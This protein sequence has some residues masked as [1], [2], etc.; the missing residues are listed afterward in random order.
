LTNSI[1]SGS[2]VS[3]PSARIT[4]DY[5]EKI[6]LDIYRL[7]NNTCNLVTILEEERFISDSDTLE[8][9]E[10]LIVDEEEC[11]IDT[12]CPEGFE[13]LNNSCQL[14]EDFEIIC[15]EG[16]DYNLE[17]DKCEKYPDTGIICLEG[18]YNTE[19]GKCEIYPQVITEEWYSQTSFMIGDFEVKLW[20][21][22]SFW[23]L[24]FLLIITGG[25]RR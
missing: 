4:L 16:F 21:L 15:P 9:C 8:E 5:E 6:Y 2:D 17:S 11:Y 7:Q 10:L 24:L 18:T 22:I 14:K 12:D 13:C 25:K 23:G 20:M 1:G 3:N 19:T